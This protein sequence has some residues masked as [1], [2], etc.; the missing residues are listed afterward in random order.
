MVGRDI[1]GRYVLTLPTEIHSRS[2]PKL[3]S[4]V[5]RLGKNSGDKTFHQRDPAQR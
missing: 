4:G 2:L 5:S 3:S 1:G